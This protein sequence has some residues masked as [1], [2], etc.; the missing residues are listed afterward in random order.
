MGPHVD[1]IDE[2]EPLQVF[3]I[4]AVALAKF[5]E[6]EMDVNYRYRELTLYGTCVARS[7]SEAGETATRV[8]FETAARMKGCVGFEMGHEHAFA[9]N[10]EICKKTSL[11]KDGLHRVEVLYTPPMSKEEMGL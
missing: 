7:Q 2:E 5:D 4:H 8:L 9:L 3:S 11:K 1:W 10:P 6:P